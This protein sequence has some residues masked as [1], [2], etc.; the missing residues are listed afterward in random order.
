MYLVY[1]NLMALEALICTGRMTKWTTL[2]YML[3]GSILFGPELLSSRFFLL[4]GDR[5]IDI[6]LN[7]YIVVLVHVV[8][9][10]DCDCA[11]SAP[12]ILMRLHSAFQWEIDH[13]ESML[14]TRVS[15]LES[16]VKYIFN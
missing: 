4:S 2:C 13:L 11:I 16:R 9:T 14:W 3:L 6:L 10:T 7:S 15:S 5:C 8:Q 1:A 12:T